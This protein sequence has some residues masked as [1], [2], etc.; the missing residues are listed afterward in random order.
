MQQSWRLLL[1]AAIA[2]PAYLLAMKRLE[3]QAVNAPEPELVTTLPLAAQVLFA[4]GDRYLAANLSGFRV[5]VA[6]TQ[7]MKDDDY[8]V[9]ARLQ[10]EIAWLNPAHEDNYYIAAAILPW[11]GQVEAGQ[12]VL[13]RA[14]QKR[15]FDWLPLFYYAFGRYHFYKDPAGGSDALRAAIPRAMDAQ[16]AM[17]LQILASVWAEKGYSTKAAA[18]VVGAMAD[19]APAGALRNY[20][21]RRAERLEALAGLR[22]AAQIYEQRLGRRPVDIGDLVGSGIL[23]S[24]PADPFGQGFMIDADGQVVIQDGKRAK[25]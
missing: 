11:A 23:P 5:L 12:R 17:A 16:D 25:R 19:D 20:L 1:I 7:R 2:F 15:T 8:A 24:I 9:Q 10:D 21:R 18:G 22:E 6:A 13:Q 14:A 3:S 4:G